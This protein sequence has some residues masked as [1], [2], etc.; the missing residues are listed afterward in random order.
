MSLNGRPY[1]MAQI[2]IR[3]LGSWVPQESWD[4]GRILVFVLRSWKNQH[5]LLS[6]TWSMPRICVVVSNN[7]SAQIPPGLMGLLLQ[8]APLE[9]IDIAMSGLKSY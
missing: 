3:A 8:K 5:A 4:A 6:T 9:V 1:I 7:Q 2:I